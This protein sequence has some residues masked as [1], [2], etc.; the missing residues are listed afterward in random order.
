FRAWRARGAAR[1]R[2]RHRP[3]LRHRVLDRCGPRCLASQYQLC[4][5]APAPIMSTSV[6]WVGELVAMVEDKRLLP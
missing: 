4:P 3:G 5:A 2:S 1:Q 6:S